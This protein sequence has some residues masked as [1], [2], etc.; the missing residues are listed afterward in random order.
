MSENKNIFVLTNF[1]PI[2]FK[3]NNYPVQYCLLCRG[4]LSDIC[5]KCVE[6]KCEK[7]N[8]INS[9]GAYYHYHCFSHLNEKNKN[10]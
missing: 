2:G 9:E 8:I 7:C 1:S 6:N 10:K 4:F 3:K 5:E